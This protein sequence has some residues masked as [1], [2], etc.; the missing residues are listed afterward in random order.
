MKSFHPGERIDKTT[1]GANKTIDKTISKAISQ[2]DVNTNE[3]V[4]PQAPLMTFGGQSLD[5][6]S[7]LRTP[8]TGFI[9]QNPYP[10]ESHDLP[11]ENPFMNF[12]QPI[13]PFVS[14]FPLNSQNM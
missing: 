1:A 7:P 2:T 6:V 9:E 4:P 5:Q 13:G 10:M 11:L 14:N 8:A 3:T 12:M